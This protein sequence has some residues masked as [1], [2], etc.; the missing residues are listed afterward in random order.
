MMRIFLSGFTRATHISYTIGLYADFNSMLRIYYFNKLSEKERLALLERQNL[1]EKE[2]IRKSVS[3]II[4]RVKKEGLRAVKEYTSRFDG[5]DIEYILVDESEFERA[6]SLL[7]ADEK[8][9]FKKAAENIR[10]FHLLQME[11][12]QDREIEIGG[13]IL[14]YKYVPVDGVALYIPGGNAS[15][16]SSVLMGM[17]PARIA[18]VKSA[19]LVTPPNSKGSVAPSIL[20]CARMMGAS[21]VLKAGGAQGIAAAAFGVSGL[22]AG[23]IIGP[24]NRYVTAAKSIL[25]ESGEIRIDLPAGPSEVVV[26][27]DE[28]ARPE[29]VAAD[30]LSQ[31]EHGSDSSAIL[32]T[33]SEKLARSVSREVVNG[34]KERPKRRELKT[35]SIKNHSFAIVFDEMN[36]AFT[37]S[38]EYAPEHLEICTANPKSDFEKITSAGSVFLGNFAPVALG[39]YFSGTNHVLPTGGSAKFYSG[40][41]VETFFKRITYQHPDKESLRRALE[42][43]K[44]MSK[45]EGFEQEHGHSLEIRFLC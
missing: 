30:L 11:A 17:I 3:E 21:G 45:I 39:D 35:A 8:A 26:I 29:Y 32:L 33:T 6:E 13:T 4:A 28:T 27:A 31:A 38:N 16:P 36:D 22:K 20:Y 40:L 7:S 10:T 15:Y 41:G 14:G 24:G 34:I 5:V 1:Q 43:I 44:I 19:F 12:L 42:P 23:L 37:F 25:N 18:G 2:D 9:A